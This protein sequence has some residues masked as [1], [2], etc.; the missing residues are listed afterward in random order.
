MCE[1]IDEKV[2]IQ[3][4]IDQRECTTKCSNNDTDGIG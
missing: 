4:T 2:G 1:N 3:I